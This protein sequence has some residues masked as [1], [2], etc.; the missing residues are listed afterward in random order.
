MTTYSTQSFTDY[1][2]KIL[3]PEQQAFMER[4]DAGILI[5][6][7]KKIKAEN[8]KYTDRTPRDRRTYNSWVNMKKRC[9]Y[10]KSP[11][12]KSYGGRGITVCETWADMHGYTAFLKDMGVRPEGTT[13]DRIDPTGNYEP[14][15]CRWATYKEQRLNQIKHSPKPALKMLDELTQF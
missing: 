14:H 15:N 6:P 13:L 3:S 11:K 10:K 12:Y 1:R 8:L 7:V 5:A 2:K 4:W 9:F